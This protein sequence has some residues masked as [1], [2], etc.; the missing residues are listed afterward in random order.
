MP[1]IEQRAEWVIELADSGNKMPAGEIC[2][3]AKVSNKCS[4]VKNF[5]MPSIKPTIL[6]TTSHY[7]P[8]YKSGGPV[9]SILNLVNNL[10]YDFDFKILA[11]DRD[12][13][14]GAHYP[15]IYYGIWNDVGCA[16][17]RYLSPE[18]QTF[19][20]VCRVIQDI[21][22]DLLYLNSF[23][24]SWNTI[25]PLVGRRI[26]KLPQCPVLLAPRGEFSISALA[27]K[28]WKKKIYISIAKSTGI[29][30]NISWHASTNFEVDDIDRT[31][32]RQSKTKLIASDLPNLAEQQLAP[33][34]RDHDEG[35][36]IVFLSRISPMK[37]LDFALEV[38]LK[39]R[40]PITF[41]IYGP[42]EDEAY[43]FHCQK[44]I[45]ALPSNIS[46]KYHGSLAPHQVTGV[47]RSNDLFF[48]PTRGENYGH[49][50]AEALAVGTPVLISDQTPW[51][52][53]EDRGLGFDLPLSDQIKF[54]EAIE[55]SV[56]MEPS[57]RLHKRIARHASM[58]E[59]QA[60]SSDVAA[61]RMMF[62]A[63]IHG[64]RIV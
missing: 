24:A 14:D 4:R 38:L 12:L 18:E 7:L 9:R 15:S 41:N 45:S 8:G 46:V 17:V 59:L 26:G 22:F 63:V 21:N 60:E 58:L 23:F 28:S 1:C 13:G 61:N 16:Q 31:I 10:H 35:L 51:R 53:L 52:G 29:L 30:N 42:L 20:E 62:R 39:V 48:L 34:S 64:E 11:A 50:I 55:N 6:I 3:S 40:L 27:L 25:W 36:H 44:I 49:V 54:V 2:T 19:N 43:W 56:R 5:K 57:E 32:G 33:S 37:N 47:L